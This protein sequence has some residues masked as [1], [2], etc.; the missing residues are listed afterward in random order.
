MVLA[1]ADL[2]LV[3]LVAT[4]LVVLGLVGRMGLVPGLVDLASVGLVVLGL[5][6]RMVTWV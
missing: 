2:A 4:G 3:V 6:G 5:V 1:D